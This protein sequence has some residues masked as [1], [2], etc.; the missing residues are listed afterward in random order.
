MGYISFTA[1]MYIRILL[2]GRNTLLYSSQVQ[3]Q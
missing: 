1:K 2:S 3:R